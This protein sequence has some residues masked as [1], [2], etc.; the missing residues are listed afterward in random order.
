M[1]LTDFNIATRFTPGTPLKSITG[2]LAYIAPE[3]YARVGYFDSPDWWALGILAYELVFNR[4][5]YYGKSHEAMAESIMKTPLSFP[6]KTPISK[7][8]Q[9]LIIGVGRR[10]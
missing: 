5:P 4:R 2:S 1:H 10:F 3:V 6:D 8:F 9:E 7:P